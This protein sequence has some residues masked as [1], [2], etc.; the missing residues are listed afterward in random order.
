MQLI[1]LFRDFMTLLL[2]NTIC[3]GLSI[4][5]CAILLLCNV[6]TLL[7]KAV[8]DIMRVQYAYAICEASHVSP[9]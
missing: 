8:N 1:V 7:K 4:I 5:K 9:Y 2:C 6:T 3:V